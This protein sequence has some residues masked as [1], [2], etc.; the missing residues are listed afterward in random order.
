MR[1]ARTPRDD[2]EW[3]TIRLTNL[4]SPHESASTLISE[5][6][7]QQQQTFASIK[8]G[9]YNVENFKIIPAADLLGE[10]ADLGP[11]S[12]GSHALTPINNQLCTEKTS[13]INETVM[14]AFS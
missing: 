14:S 2:G 6:K 5:A 9:Q 7:K 10:N 13:L 12:L 8:S 3:R 11:D 1:P 4:N